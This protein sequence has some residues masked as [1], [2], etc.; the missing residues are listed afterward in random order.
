MANAH[1]GFEA[2]FSGLSAPTLATTRS[3]VAATDAD[4][5]E[6]R[7]IAQ[8]FSEQSADNDG[9]R[10]AAIAALLFERDERVLTW[11]ERRAT[12][13]PHDAERWNDLAAARLTVALA[14]E[15]IDELPRALSDVDHALE[16]AP[17]FSPA[18][19]NRALILEQ[20]GIRN[21]AVHEWQLAGRNGDEWAEQ[22][23]TRARRLRSPKSSA[24]SALLS[25]ALAAARAGNMVPL[26]ALARDQ[27][28]LTRAYGEGPLFATWAAAVQRHHSDD[29]AIALADVRHVGEEL[30]LRNH[31]FLISDS[32]Q[33]IDRATG[34][35]M[36]LRLL[37]DAHLAYDHARRAYSRNEAG[38]DISLA[39]AVRLFVRADSPMQ[40]AARYYA[41]NATFDRN[42]V[43]QSRMQLLSLESKLDRR[44]YPS[45]FAGVQWEL[46]RVTAETGL[47][48]LAV[49]HA[50]QSHAQYV[51]LGESDNA[52]F[53]QAIQADIADRMGEHRHAWV[54][55]RAALDQLT[56]GHDL[57][58]ITAVLLS[59]LQSRGENEAA[60]ERSALARAAVDLARGGDAELLNEALLRVAQIEGPRTGPSYISEV[61]ATLSQ[62]ND[63][64]VRE[65]IFASVN[66]TEAGLLTATTPCTA[67]ALLKT[68]VDFYESHEYEAFLPAA[69]LA[70]ARASRLCGTVDAAS[71]DCRRGLAS[72]ARQR[73]RIEAHELRAAMLEVKTKLV[74][75][76]VVLALAEGHVR[77]ALALADAARAEPRERRS[78]ATRR[79]RRDAVIEY[80]YLPDG[81]AIFCVRGDEVTV[82][83]ARANTQEIANLA[84]RFRELAENH[85]DS[86]TLTKLAAE[87]HERLIAPVATEI[88]TAR[89]VVIVPQRALDQVPFAALYDARRQ[90]YLIEDHDLLVTTS[91]QHVTAARDRIARGTALVIGD[92]VAGGER[93]SSARSEAAAIAA[94]YSHSRLLLGRE[95]TIDRFMREAPQASFIHY[96]GHARGDAIKGSVALLFTPGRDGED[97]L[98]GLSLARL[99]LPRQPIIVLAACAT[100]SSDVSRTEGAP[101]LP[102]AFLQAGARNVIGTLW[103]IDDSASELL[104][105]NVHRRLRAG[106][107]AVSALAATQRELL[108]SKTAFSNPSVWSSVQ[109]RGG[110]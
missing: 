74:E 41:A 89:N 38:S 101:G 59:G 26:R 37:A 47:W 85:R 28:Q 83:V 79:D 23:F 62:I 77:K 97:R 57:Y 39:H 44:R 10:V 90:R 76:S 21:V 17:A 11:F 45:L 16:T 95:A 1:R 31:D 46:T 55:R 86:A 42:Q 84:S 94:M 88:R 109:I 51:A 70:R 98:D 22:A 27:A 43:A 91:S 7:A 81:L 110:L 6:L 75:E 100:L 65:R 50:E 2:R 106:E 5:L 3:S 96:A 24:F 49:R 32:A 66:M 40:A 4:A 71:R 105:V 108:R 20:L 34:D 103:S 68:A 63:K 67:R 82:S 12:H 102:A 30:A 93:L 33:A 87:L 69:Y 29:A 25:A 60:A 14:G 35:P 19:W 92:P 104:F 73:D 18:R 56:R 9:A 54:M 36:R 8:R 15:Q 107:S 52:A 99:H 80:A 48:S 72:V 58:K 13:A 64:A 61:R 53:L 78:R